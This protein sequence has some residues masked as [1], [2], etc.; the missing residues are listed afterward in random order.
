MPFPLNF[1]RSIGR[2]DEGHLTRYR[3]AFIG[4]RRLHRLMKLKGIQDFLNC[5]HYEP[6]FLWLSPHL[7]Q[8]SGLESI[9][10]SLDIDLREKIYKGDEDSSE[11]VRILLRSL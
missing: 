6:R 5:R 8:N 2:K 10:C 11:K 7:R 9:L 3:M 1:F 4:N